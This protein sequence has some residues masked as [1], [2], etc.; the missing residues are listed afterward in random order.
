MNSS[1]DVHYETVLRAS[2]DYEDARD[3]AEA[4]HA[5]LLTATS[6]AASTARELLEAEAQLEGA[7]ETVGR[8]IV[9]ERNRRSSIARGVYVDAAEEAPAEAV[10]P[11]SAPADPVVTPHPDANDVAF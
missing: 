9:M 7:I 2:R 8:Q 11:P 6:S 4:A 10:A 1:I 5:R 3:H